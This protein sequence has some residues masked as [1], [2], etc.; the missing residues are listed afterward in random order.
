LKGS[1]RTGMK[2]PWLRGALI[3]LQFTISISLLIGT[4]IVFNQLKYMQNKPLGFSK[5]Q[6][7][8][9]PIETKAGRQSYATFR[10]ELMQHSGVINVTASDAIPGHFTNENAYR[11]PGSQDGTLYHFSRGCVSHDYLNTLQI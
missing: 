9:F 11:S 5:E 6:V 3:V 2:T 4:G 8:V 7:V 10:K 1:L